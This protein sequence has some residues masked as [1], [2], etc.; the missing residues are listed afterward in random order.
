MFNSYHKIKFTKL[1][2]KNKNSPRIFVDVDQAI[3]FM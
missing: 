1:K 2:P 3:L